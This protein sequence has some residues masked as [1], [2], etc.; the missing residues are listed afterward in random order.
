MTFTRD[1]AVGAGT[2]LATQVS[3]NFGSS[4]AGLLIPVVAYILLTR[5][6]AR[7][8]RGLD[9]LTVAGVV[10]LALLAPLAVLLVDFRTLSWPVLGLLAAI[11]LLC[12]AVP[13]SLDTFILR[14][15]TP[16]LYAIITSCSPAIAAVFGWLVLSEQSS[17]QQLLA[18]VIVCVA[19]GIAIA[20]QV[21]PT[22]SAG[23]AVESA[24]EASALSR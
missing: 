2:Q 6:V 9:G 11:G 12:S 20:S 4:I 10:A 22:S 18:I 8:Y 24:S 17:A 1:R 7:Q 23:N 16:R 5:R 13:Y 21:E 3:I 14:R 15:I 19:A